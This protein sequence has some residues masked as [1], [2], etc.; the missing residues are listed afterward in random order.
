M[1]DL[2]MTFE[3]WV[4]FAATFWGLVHISAASFSFKS[5]VGNEYTAGSRDE[6]LQPKGLAGRL[7]RAQRNFMETYPLFAVLAILLYLSGRA[8]DLSHWGAW[9][10][11]LGRVIYLP[12]YA[13]GIAWVRSICWAFATLGLVLVGVQILL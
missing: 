3:L 11:I 13:S 1:H 12:L 10:Y 5:Q 8:G 6:G 7:N 2:P 9:M 4:L